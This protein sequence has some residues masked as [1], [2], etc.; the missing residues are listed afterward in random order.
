MSTFER[1]RNKKI[2]TH[3]LGSVL[4]PTS[5]IIFLIFIIVSEL[6][7]VPAQ[8]IFAQ[9]SLDYFI[10]EDK[11]YGYMILRLTIGVVIITAFYSV[12]MIWLSRAKE[13]LPLK[14][15]D[16]EFFKADIACQQKEAHLLLNLSI[17]SIDKYKLSDFQ[18]KHLDKEATPK[19]I[20]ELLKIEIKKAQ[21]TK[22]LPSLE[23]SD[24][25]KKFDDSSLTNYN[26][27]QGLI[28][29]N[30]YLQRGV[31]LHLYIVSSTRSEEFANSF[32]QLLR[33][34]NTSNLLY[35]IHLVSALDFN[36]MEECAIALDT[37]VRRLEKDYPNHPVIIDIT[38]GTVPISIA[39]TTV[40]FAHDRRFQYLPMQTKDAPL[41]LYSAKYGTSEDN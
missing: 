27:R 38:G 22:S 24:F 16:E 26:W 41:R 20:L 39:G 23:S 4:T 32:K 7:V 17:P 11:S 10:F 35:G 9:L 6:I 1:Q 5:L 40:S 37:K 29:I 18:E 12:A 25:R 30:A 13:T 2:L 14:I 8:E 3:L 34:I 15:T 28:V 31:P 19:E 36:N 21:S 33:E